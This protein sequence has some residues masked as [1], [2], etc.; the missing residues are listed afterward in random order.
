MSALIAGVGGRPAGSLSR[1]CSCASGWSTPS[2]T[3][4]TTRRDCGCSA[5][6]HLDHHRVARV[7]ERRRVIGGLIGSAFAGLGV[8]VRWHLLVTGV[9]F[10][11][12]LVVASRFLMPGHEPVPGAEPP[13]QDGETGPRAR[14]GRAPRVP[15]GSSSGCCWSAWSVW[16]A[17]PARTP[18]TPGRALPDRHARHHGRGRRGGVRRHAEHHDHRQVRGD[19]LVT[20]FGPREVSR[21]GGILTVLGFAVVLAVPSVVAAVVGFGIVGLG[22]AVLIRSPCTPPTSCRGCRGASVWRSR[23]G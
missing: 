7:V 9:L 17:P 16:P 4:P 8:P 10:A 6:R 5:D 13:E 21:V 12:V 3:S 23:G 2:S 20:R 14:G 15:A 18:A 1:P 11:L 19:P 22:I